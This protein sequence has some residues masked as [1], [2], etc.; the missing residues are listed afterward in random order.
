MKI[1]MSA[2]TTAVGICVLLALTFVWGCKSGKKNNIQEKADLHY[3]V[4]RNHFR[5]GDYV[6][7][8][9]E[10]LQ[11]V[12][13][14]KENPETQYLLGTTYYML[15]RYTQAE[16]H[17]KYAI[18]LKPDYPDA[19][20][21]LGN[22]Y[23]ATEQWD[24]AITQFEKCL[25]FI[26]YQPNFPQVYTNM[27]IAYMRKGELEKAEDSFRTAI[28]LNEKFCP[29]RLNLGDLLGKRNK[30]NEALRE[31]EKVIEYCP[32]SN[33]SMVA[34]LCMGMELNSMNRHKEAC[35]HFLKVV[36]QKPD[37]ETGRKAREY[38]R[39]LNCR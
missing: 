13:F 1:I 15:D 24:K 38:L 22:I 16:E 27:G 25:D 23:L 33:Y 2:R 36:Q 14:K 26:L 28:R 10:L 9:K 8:L 4:G 35:R 3:E 18:K 5:R 34:H 31:Y 11:S 17:L 39:L 21:N 37:S 7:A 30:K 20:N 32:D 29:A 19:I 6:A 12:E